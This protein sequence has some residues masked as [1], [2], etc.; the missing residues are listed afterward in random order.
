MTLTSGDRE[1][2]H[3]FTV[4]LPEDDFWSF[5]TPDPD[6]GDYPLRD[7]LGVATLDDT[8]VEGAVIADLQGFGLSGFLTEG[9]GVDEALI[10]PDRARLDALSGCV[11]IVKGAAFDGA[12]VPITPR[13]PVAHFGSWHMVAP[14][15]TMEPLT[16]AAAQGT[17]SPGA[18]QGTAPA[19]TNRMTLWLLI[20]IAALILLA[21]LFGAFA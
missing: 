13:P 18:G 4:D 21:L 6:T 3:L 7:A 12:Q 20:G 2:V 17:L 8:Q 1:T 9:I 11:A 10:A 14:E 5:V 15:T 16:S 19:R